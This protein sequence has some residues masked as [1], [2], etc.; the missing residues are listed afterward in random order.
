MKKQPEWHE[1]SNEGAQNQAQDQK[2]LYRIVNIGCKA[3]G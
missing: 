3:S 2:A 1:F